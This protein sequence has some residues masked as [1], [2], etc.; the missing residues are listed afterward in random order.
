M[1][2]QMEEDIVIPPEEDSDPEN[3]TSVRTSDSSSRSSYAD[4]RN[5]QGQDPICGKFT[6]ESFADESAKPDTAISCRP[7]ALYFYLSLFLTVIL[8]ATAGAKKSSGYRQLF[9]QTFS[10]SIGYSSLCIT[11]FCTVFFAILA[12]F[13][14]S[15]IQ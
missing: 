13:T 1:G 12:K 2:E 8:L 15:F 4:W 10:H 9:E 6:P 11:G 7:S 3:L 5:S 14:V